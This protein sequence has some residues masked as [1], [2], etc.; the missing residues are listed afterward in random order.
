MKNKKILIL[1]IL[2]LFLLYLSTS[3]YMPNVGPIESELGDIPGF[4][5]L[6]ITSFL[7]GQAILQLF[8]GPLSD[9]YGRY[10]V[11]V[12]ALLVFIFANILCYFAWD[13]ISLVIFR[14]IQGG[15]V[16]SG[17]VLGAIVLS[18]VVPRGVIG[19]YI[20]I[21][22][23]VPLLAPPIGS[24][25][26]GAIG[27]YLNWRFTFLFLAILGSITFILI[28]LYLPETLDK[29]KTEPRDIF[30]TISLF[31]NLDFTA[32]SLLGLTLLGTY[33]SFNLFFSLIL[34][35]TYHFTPFNVGIFLTLYG[36]VDS[37]S[38]FVGG[39]ISDRVPTL[40]ILL[41]SS[42]IAGFGSLMFGTLIGAD[43]YFLLISFM[44]FGVGI[45]LSTVP[46]MTYIMDLSRNSRGAA[47]GMTNFVRLIGAA[48]VPFGGQFVRE[49]LSS[50]HLFYLSAIL[51]FATVLLAWLVCEEK[52]IVDN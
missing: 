37:F 14:A 19:K 44:V 46:L 31:K 17:Y 39:K 35:Q 45:G 9:K 22:M 33:F 36:M 41:T 5:S 4:I 30:S 27:E 43:P 13:G 49:V 10:T 2:P 18:D 24:F 26:G 38:V 7:A 6:T 21:F 42:T 32:V 48:M 16:S 52:R 15:A 47:L 23:A 25:I 40:K 20:G 50:S 34:D 8:Y 28:T 51:I 11:F 3:I 1:V 12:P 29:R